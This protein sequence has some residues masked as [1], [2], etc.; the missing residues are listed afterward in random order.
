MRSNHRPPGPQAT[1]ARRQDLLGSVLEKL[2]GDDPASLRCGSP[3]GRRRHSNHG[4]E[5]DLDATL[6][7]RSREQERSGGRKH[8]CLDLW[9]DHLSP[10]HHGLRGLGFDPRAEHHGRHDQGRRG[11]EAAPLWRKGPFSSRSLRLGPF[12]LSSRRRAPSVAATCVK[13][14]H[15]NFAPQATTKQRLT[16]SSPAV[17]ETKTNTRFPV[18]CWLPYP[19]SS[20]GSGHSP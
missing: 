1:G 5:P 11:S 19:L 10:D 20:P 13:I 12:G 17:C 15:S 18:A 3:T 14:S 4:R 16:S 2:D 9:V 8:S 7:P 6:R